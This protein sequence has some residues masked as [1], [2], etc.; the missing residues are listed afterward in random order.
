MLSDSIF[1]GSFG[2]CLHSWT[3]TRTLCSANEEMQERAVV[4]QQFEKHLGSGIICRALMTCLHIQHW[5]TKVINSDDVI[6]KHMD[7]KQKN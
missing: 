2:I 7:Y 6:S 3:F 1:P 5:R 4:L